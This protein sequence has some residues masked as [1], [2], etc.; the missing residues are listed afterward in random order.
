[1]VDL[2]SELPA[3]YRQNPHAAIGRGDDHLGVAG[4]KDQVGDPP[5]GVRRKSSLLPID[6][7][8]GPIEI[9]AEPVPLWIGIPGFIVFSGLTLLLAGYQIRRMEI[10]YAED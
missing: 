3:F 8:D 1:M 6:I 7:S 2:G 4:R 5:T 9:I 10:R